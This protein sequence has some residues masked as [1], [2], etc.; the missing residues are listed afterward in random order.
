MSTH[1]LD[2]VSIPYNVHTLNLFQPIKALGIIKH[3][4][5]LNRLPW[6]RLNAGHSLSGIVLLALGGGTGRLGPLGV[7]LDP[8]S[9][10][11]DGH[12]VRL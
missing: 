8:L 10:F 12:G 1:K 9:L 3:F 6:E 11:V 5:N 7:S 2:S 4:R